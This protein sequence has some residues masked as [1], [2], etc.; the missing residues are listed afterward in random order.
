MDHHTNSKSQHGW[1]PSMVYFGSQDD[2]SGSFLLAEQ[3]YF[4]IPALI[5]FSVQ[6]KPFWKCFYKYPSKP[7]PTC[8]S[9]LSS[10]AGSGLPCLLPAC[11]GFSCGH[12]NFCTCQHICSSLSGCKVL[13]GPLW[14]GTMSVF[15]V[16]SEVPSSEQVSK[17]LLNEWLLRC[18][19]TTL[20]FKRLY[21][22]LLR[23]VYLLFYVK[24]HEKSYFLMQMFKTAKHSIGYECCFMS[25]F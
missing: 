21:K 23:P 15:L 1:K 13:I 20:L 16:S 8:V 2:L 4:L 18:N 11:T 7:F 10:C 12:V 19:I 9:L 3:P 24:Y 22:N 17:C 5:I 25:L 6:F 14:V